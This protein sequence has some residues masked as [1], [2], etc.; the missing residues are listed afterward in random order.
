MIHK[1]ILIQKL[2]FYILNFIFLVFFNSS[3]GWMVVHIYDL[4]ENSASSNLNDNKVQISKVDS[5]TSDGTYTV[6][7][8]IFISLTFSEPVKVSNLISALNPPTIVLETGSI[9]TTVTLDNLSSDGLTLT[10][11]YNIKIGDDSLDLDYV[12]Y[13]SLSVGD[14][15]IVSNANSNKA[16]NSKLPNQDSGFSLANL[17]NFIIDTKPHLEV[18]LQHIQLEESNSDNSYP[19]LIT[20]SLNYPRSVNTEIIFTHTSQL[21]NS[22]DYSVSTGTVTP[23]VLTIPAGSTSINLGI[24]VIGDTGLRETDKVIDFNFSLNSDFN[25][26]IIKRS[27][28]LVDDDL[29]QLSVLPFYPTSGTMWNSYITSGSLLKS[30]NRYLKI[31]ASQFPQIETPCVPLGNVECIHSAEVMRVNVSWKSNCNNITMKDSLDAF[32]WRCSESQV[33][34]F[35]YSVGFKKDRGLKDLIKID[36]SDW[37]AI[38][39]TLFDSAISDTSSLNSVWWN[40]PISILN[41][42]IINSAPGAPRLSLANAN[43]IYA[44]TENIISRG[45]NITNDGIALVVLPGATLSAGTPLTALNCEPFWVTGTTS[46]FLSLRQKYF[47]WIEGTFVGINSSDVITTSRG[48]AQ[49]NTVPRY[50]RIHNSNIS[51]GNVGLQISSLYFQITDITLSN[52]EFGLYLFSADSNLISDVKISS[53]NE[54]SIIVDV[55]SADNLIVNATVDARNNNLP[56]VIMGHHSR[57]NYFRI[58]N[59]TTDLLKI[60]DLSISITDGLLSNGANGITGFSDH[61]YISQISTINNS[62]SGHAFSAGAIGATQI[63]NSELSVNNNIGINFTS[64]INGSAKLYD[65]YS[66]DNSTNEI[67]IPNNI[68]DIYWSGNL[69]LGRGPNKCS[70]GIN[71][72]NIG[73]IDSNCNPDVG[74]TISKMNNI[75]SN[76]LFTK[77]TTDTKNNQGSSGIVGL[78]FSSILDYH[79]FENMFRFWVPLDNSSFPNSNIRGACD[80]NSCGIFEAKLQNEITNLKNI[81]GIFKSGE[82]CPAKTMG[83]KAIF[84]DDSWSGSSYVLQGTIEFSLDGVGDDDGRC[85]N[86]ENCYFTPS[87]GANLDEPWTYTQTCNYEPD[88]STDITN[89]KIFGR[90]L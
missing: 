85:E 55:L 60:S 43:T 11:I 38:S 87:A 34:I 25:N 21:A 58:T 44:I 82:T 23:Y 68:Q 53:T 27:I 84:I 64:G 31:D 18:N 12:N 5:I 57:L 79:T 81:N 83:S 20:L 80:N 90:E 24:T 1:R 49:N 59:G 14:W 35:F 26:Q 46:C 22:S 30:I 72:T 50:G 74:T 16:L 65:I 3:C 41:S 76:S 88:G 54:R 6:G 77:F 66:I 71:T 45:I 4:D 7:Q 39:V 8:S 69:F 63:I 78:L 52:L 28:T 48:T 47:T 56:V 17:H 73:L 29:K 75:D 61:G 86:N 89:V 42:G 32:D 2:F 40:N 36:G 67:L 19:E 33:P 9:D 10:G 37:K 62:L 15:S 51:T 13:D 70:I